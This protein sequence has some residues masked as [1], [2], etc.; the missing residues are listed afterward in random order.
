[1]SKKRNCPICG[2]FLKGNGHC[3]LEFYDKVQ[4]TWEHEV[5]WE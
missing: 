5:S 4:D 3:K 1:M 2:Y